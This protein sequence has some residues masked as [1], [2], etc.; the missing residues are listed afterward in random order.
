MINK[1]LKEI[2][3]GYDGLIRKIE[4]QSFDSAVV[5]ISV[6]KRTNREWVNVSFQLKG[7][8]EFAVKQKP[9]NTNVVLS[10]GIFYMAINNIHYIDFSPYSDSME[11]ENDFRMSDVYFA[12]DLIEYEVL[13]YSE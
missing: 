6:M 5:V 3:H 11:N 8:K 7:L 10:G 4:F 12:S 9:N 13:P 1:F 2:T